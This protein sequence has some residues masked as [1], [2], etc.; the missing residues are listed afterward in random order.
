M[1][2]DAKGDAKAPIAAS[3]SCSNYTTKPLRIISP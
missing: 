3:R 1:G 2:A